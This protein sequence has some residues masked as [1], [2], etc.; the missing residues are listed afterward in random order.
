[1]KFHSL[2]KKLIIK[3]LKLFTLF[4]YDVELNFKPLKYANPS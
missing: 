2:N 3:K 1:M 4:L